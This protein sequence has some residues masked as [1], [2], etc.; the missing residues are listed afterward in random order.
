MEAG[1]VTN[2]EQGRMDAALDQVRAAIN[3]ISGM[4]PED[5]GYLD[6]PI[7]IVA[8]TQAGGVGLVTR[9]VHPS[10]VVML[11]AQLLARLTS[12]DDPTV[13]KVHVDLDKGE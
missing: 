13:F 4:T 10:M 5:A 8:R 2:E 3:D 12:D 1:F 11:L 6:G 7:I 9:K